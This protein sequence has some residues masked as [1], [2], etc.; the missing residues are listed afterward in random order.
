MLFF[1]V[2]FNTYAANF[3]DQSSMLC[4]SYFK[5]GWVVGVRSRSSCDLSPTKK[6]VVDDAESR[7][8]QFSHA[9]EVRCSSNNS[10]S[11]NI[12]NNN[13]GVGS[14]NVALKTPT[15]ASLL[16][17]TVFWWNLFEVI[18]MVRGTY[19]WKYRMLNLIWRNVEKLGCFLSGRDL[20]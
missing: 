18:K 9:S 15:R 5:T 4:F 13:F 6:C 20:N 19:H 2:S 1:K 12:S 17:S 10:S 11:N 7:T 3:T 14:Q 16:Y 8:T